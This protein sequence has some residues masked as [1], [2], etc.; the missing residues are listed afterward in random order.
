MSRAAKAF[1]ASSILVTGLTVWGVHF[2]QAREEEAMYQ[3]VIKDEA[4]MKARAARKSAETTPTAPPST[5]ETY[6]GLAPPSATTAQRAAEYS[7]NLALQQELARE[8]GME[9]AKVEL[10]RYEADRE[11]VR[12]QEAREV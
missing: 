11:V 9:R 7:R 6:Q 5:Q 1:L 10:Q 4:R 2:I 8:Q 12:R 3:G